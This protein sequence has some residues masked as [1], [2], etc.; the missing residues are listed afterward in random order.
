[1]INETNWHDEKGV[2]RA[3]TGAAFVFPDAEGNLVQGNGSGSG[4]F[5]LIGTIPM[6]KQGAGLITTDGVNVLGDDDVNFE[7]DGVKQGDFLYNGGAGVAAVRKIVS[8]LDSKRLILEGAFPADLTDSPVLVCGRQDFKLIV[9]DNTH[10]DADAIIQEAAFSSGKNFLNGGAPIAYN[11][12][13]SQL[14][15]TCHK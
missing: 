13:S 11:A 3:R 6:A 7:T 12:T 15:F 9:V 5:P 4:V 2:Y 10:E 1:M 14:D 8:V